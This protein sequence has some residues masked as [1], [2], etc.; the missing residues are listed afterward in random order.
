MK[1]EFALLNPEEEDDLTRDQ[2]AERLSAIST[3][4]HYVYAVWKDLPKG[5]FYILRTYD[6]A[7]NIDDDD[8]EKNCFTVDEFLDRFDSMHPKD[9]F[10]VVLKVLKSESED[11]DPDE[12]YLSYSDYHHSDDLSVEQVKDD[13]NE[14]LEFYCEK[15]LRENR[16]LY[17]TD[18]T[19]RHYGFTDEDVKILTPVLARFNGEAKNRIRAEYEQLANLDFIRAEI[20]KR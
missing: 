18:E 17:L 6:I 10:F 3:Q 12:N 11:V 2:L 8:D 4:A 19:I 7:A 13:F 9:P 14:F 15:R 16:P 5:N 20:E 1:E